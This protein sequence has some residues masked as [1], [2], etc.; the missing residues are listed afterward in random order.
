MMRY[1]GEKSEG[2]TG[3]VDNTGQE[4]GIGQEPR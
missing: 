2:S 3:T 4:A 1:V